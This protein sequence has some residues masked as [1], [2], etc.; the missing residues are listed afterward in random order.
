M[1]ATVTG[2]VLAMVRKGRAM[3]G[4]ERRLYHLC[5]GRPVSWHEF[6]RTI[7]ARA[8]A[9]PGFK[10]RLAPD[11]I[12][13]IPGSEYPAAAFRP[14]NSRLDCSRLERDFDLRMPDWEP[15]LLRMLQLLSLKQN[16]Y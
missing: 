4:E 3:N 6:A 15:Y 12:I 16:G 8:A 11:A 2:V 1:I 7:V 9:M 10:L 14:A 13:A 5:C